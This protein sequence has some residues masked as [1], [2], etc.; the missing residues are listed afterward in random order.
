MKGNPET[1]T[2][3]YRNKT[4]PESRTPATSGE[5]D[6]VN[7]A[8]QPNS[9]TAVMVSNSGPRIGRPHLQD[10]HETTR[11]QVGNNI[12]KT[13]GKQWGDEWKTLETIG[14]PILGDKWE[15]WK[16]VGRQF[17]DIW[18]TS[19]RQLLEGQLGDH[20][21]TGWQVEDNWKTPG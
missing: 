16:A 13:T 3:K 12:W 21:T 8:L 6:T 17:W 9:P 4:N 10:T 5:P 2:I 1:N 7:P 14:R 11:W 15:L 18:E 20:S 19:R